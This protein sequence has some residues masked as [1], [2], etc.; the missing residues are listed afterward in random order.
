MRVFSVH[1]ESGGAGAAT[2]HPLPASPCWRGAPPPPSPREHRALGPQGLHERLLGHQWTGQLRWGRGR[3]RGQLVSL[4]RSVFSGDRVCL[5][6][7]ELV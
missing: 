1:D 3:G 2:V 7:T 4:V 6:G 5:V